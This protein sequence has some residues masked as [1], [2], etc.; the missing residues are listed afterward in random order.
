MSS[1]N[2]GSKGAYFATQLS[3]VQQL[4]HLET[5][6]SRAILKWHNGLTQH[7]ESSHPDKRPR[8]YKKESDL[9]PRI[10]LQS[11]DVYS[12][13]EPDHRELPLASSLFFRTWE[14]L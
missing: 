7:L 1:G 6:D 3:P 12:L 11:M 13:Q 14:M 10:L 5:G 2:L 8:D 9:Q 4:P